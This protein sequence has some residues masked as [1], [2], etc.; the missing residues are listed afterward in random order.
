M[1]Q[2]L[3]IPETPGQ[4]VMGEAGTSLVGWIYVA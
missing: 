3:V 2:E 1:S 4:L